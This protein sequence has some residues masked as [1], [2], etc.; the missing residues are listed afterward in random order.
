MTKKPDGLACC[1]AGLAQGLDQRGNRCIL[2]D[3]SAPVL[4]VDQVNVRVDLP[5]ALD[6]LGSATSAQASPDHKARDRRLPGTL[7][8]QYLHLGHYGASER[9]QP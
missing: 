9:R 4:P 3:K 6:R 1:A 8:L 5:Q 7:A 2:T